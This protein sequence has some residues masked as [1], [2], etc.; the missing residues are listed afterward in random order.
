M[1]YGDYGAHGETEVKDAKEATCTEE[2][3]TGDQHCKVCGEMLEKGTAIAKT[4]HTYE[5]GKC[6]VCGAADPNYTPNSPQTGDNSHMALW[7][8]LLFVSGVGLAGTTVFG[9][10]KRHAR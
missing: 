2:G 3:Y 10:K 4:A 6:K 9:R 5:N 7:I 8:A 1:A